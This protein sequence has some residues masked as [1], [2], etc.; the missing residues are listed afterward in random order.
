MSFLV[1]SAIPQNEDGSYGSFEDNWWTGDEYG[2]GDSV[3]VTISSSESIKLPHLN[4]TDDS[5]SIPNGSNV[6]TTM[7]SIVV[8]SSQDPTGYANDF[9]FVGLTKMNVETG[10]TDGAWTC[11]TIQNTGDGDGDGGDGGGRRGMLDFTARVKDVYESNS[12]RR[13]EMFTSERRM[14]VID[15]TQLSPTQKASILASIPVNYD[16]RSVAVFNG[17]IPLIASAQDQ[18]ACSTC[19]AFAGSAS[20]RV[21]VRVRVALG[22]PNRGSYSTHDTTPH[23]T[24]DILHT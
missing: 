10:S 4:S 19:W 14:Q 20:V 1:P 11:G 23:S 5:N 18:G 8:P 3:Y 24:H 17:Q 15:G 2:D 9:K 6:T 16:V 21:S 13:S 22:C 12:F 7:P